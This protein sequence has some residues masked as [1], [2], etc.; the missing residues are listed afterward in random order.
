MLI[1]IYLTEEACEEQHATKTLTTLF[2]AFALWIGSLGTAYGET[3]SEGVWTKKSNKIKGSWAIEQ[4]EDGAYLVLDEA[5][6]TRNAPDLKFVLSNNTVAGVNGK[7]AME[8][9]LFV[10]NLKSNKGAQSYR[11]PDN[12]GDYSTLLYTANNFPSFGAR[13][14]F[15]NHLL[16]IQSQSLTQ[17]I[18]KGSNTSGSP[19]LLRGLIR[20]SS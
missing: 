2:A 19:G 13:L 16:T 12:Y 9:A 3:I 5:F 15:S 17:A 6:K 18:A 1:A 4:R 10:E 7:N 11:L 14:A 8:E 20:A